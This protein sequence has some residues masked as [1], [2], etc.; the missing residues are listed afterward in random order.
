[1]HYGTFPLLSG[2]P[3]EF[4][5]AL[6]ASATRVLVPEPGQKLDF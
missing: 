2:T 6:G 5:A 3:A 4:T 1:M